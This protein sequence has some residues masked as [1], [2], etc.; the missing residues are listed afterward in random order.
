MQKFLV[1]QDS[2]IH[3]NFVVHTTNPVVMGFKKTLSS[4]IKPKLQH[5]TSEIIQIPCA[6]MRC[7]AILEKTLQPG[8]SHTKQPYYQPVVELKY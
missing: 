5:V 2:L 7:T 3:L 1:A 8:V 4:S 6:C